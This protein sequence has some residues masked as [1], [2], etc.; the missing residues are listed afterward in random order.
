VPTEEITAVVEN[1]TIKLPP[2]VHLPDGLKVRVLW[3]KPDGEAT[4]YDR[5]MLTDDD[6]QAEI[7]WAT[8]RR[9]PP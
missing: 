9:F 7:Q 3:E 4:Q 6:V 1:G 5:E 2:D 8:G